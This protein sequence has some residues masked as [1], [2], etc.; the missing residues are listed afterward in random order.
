MK[1]PG[2]LFLITNHMK[3]KVY[4]LQDPQPDRFL[5]RNIEKLIIW[6]TITETE[7]IATPDL[8]VLTDKFF[9]KN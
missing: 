5:V 3:K 8:I 2:D 6:L 9:S 1:A 4:Y 7:V